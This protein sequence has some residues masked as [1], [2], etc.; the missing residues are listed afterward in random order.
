VEQIRPDGGH[1]VIGALVVH[2]GAD[3]DCSV[4]AGHRFGFDAERTDLPARHE[5]DVRR[6]TLDPISAR[7][8]GCR[9][10]RGRFEDDELGPDVQGG[11][12]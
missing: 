2:D 11:V 5:H 4:G 3:G 8:A 6:H 10:D 9:L 7:D 1:A 12:G